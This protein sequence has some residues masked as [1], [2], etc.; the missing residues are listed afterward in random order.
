MKR[1]QPAPTN[2]ED[3]SG[4]EKIA[5]DLDN[6]VIPADPDSSDYQTIVR[7]LPSDN[8]SLVTDAEVDEFLTN[9]AS[10]PGVVETTNTEPGKP[11]SST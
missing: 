10:E 7:E 8:A 2:L 11:G 9:G 1:E 6:K 3:V 5:T 4:W